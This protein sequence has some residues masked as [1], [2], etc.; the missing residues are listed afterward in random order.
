MI[1][2]I[3]IQMGFEIIVKDS[4]P[5]ES[6]KNIEKAVSVF[7]TEIGYLTKGK[8]REIPLKMFLECFVKRPDKQ[9]TVDD[10]SFKLEISK[11]TVYR[12]L[13]KLKNMDLLEESLI[14]TENAKKKTYRLRHSNLS[15]AWNFTDAHAKIALENYRKTIEHI[16][17]LVEVV[18]E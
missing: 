4:I 1:L 15:K 11:P 12:H 2:Y 10:I 18:E 5:I 8:D 14:N 3:C 13:K 7:L 17:K 9:W 6:E 16:Q